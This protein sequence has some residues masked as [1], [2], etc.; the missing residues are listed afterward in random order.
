MVKNDLTST[1]HPVQESEKAAEDARPEHEIT[2]PEE[3]KSRWRIVFIMVALV[4]AVFVVSLDNFIMAPALPSIAVEFQVTDAGFAWIG[5]SILLS[6]AVCV[7]IWAKLSDIFGRRKLIVI[8]NFVFLLGTFLGGFAINATMLIAGCAV[9]GAG[10]GGMLVLA[11]IC[12]ADLFSVR[13]RGLYLGII[14]AFTAI[15]SAVGPTVGGAVT[16]KASWRWCFWINLPFI[17]VSLVLLLCLLDIKS[18][19]TTFREGLRAVDWL[20]SISIVGA[21]LLF[22]V[23]LQLGGV[24]YP[25]NSA[26]VICLLI[27]GVLGFVIFGVVE[28]R[29]ARFPLIPLHF[30][31]RS[32]RVAALSVNVAQSMVS[33]GA[34]YFLPLYYQM[35]F[36]VSPLMSGVY[37]LPFALILSPCFPLV[38]YMVKKTGKYQIWILSGALALVIGSGIMVAAKSYTDWALVVVPQVFLALGQGLA[39]Q[40][41]LIAFQAQIDQKDV[42]TGTSTYQFLRTFSQMVSIV[43]GQVIFQTQIQQGASKFSSLGLPSGLVQ[44]LSSGN[45]IAAT[46]VIKQ[47]TAKQQTVIH[48]VIVAALNRMWI[49]YV[50]ISVLG[51][52]ASMLVKGVELATH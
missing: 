52:A 36:G 46:S 17:A 22:L 3:Q 29:Q 42:A 14:G 49:L 6:C 33:S 2:R 40:A 13:E 31:T 15:A 5:S 4:L 20:G 25:W 43:I 50:A 39:Y 9:Q 51:L 47:L 8:T 27:F 19:N 38:G 1:V 30:F 12:V 37:L 26:T 28:Q 32:S 45:I 48:E 23:G 44:Q 10:C 21:S 11:N 18:P 35:V 7:P 24:Q 34:K 16:S 41:P